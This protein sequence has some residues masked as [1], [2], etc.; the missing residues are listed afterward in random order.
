MA[1]DALGHQLLDRRSL[2]QFLGL[3][4]SSTIPDAK[5]IWLFRDRLAQAGLGT[6]AT[7]RAWVGDVFGSLAQMGGK[8]VRCLVIVCTTFALNQKA[9]SY[10]LKRL[11]FLNERGLAAF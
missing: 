3:T 9:A 7:P 10:N 8:L 2:H 1:D 11:V 6:I 4:E 5:T